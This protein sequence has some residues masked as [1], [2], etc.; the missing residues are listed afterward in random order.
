MTQ[1][2]NVFLHVTET[3]NL[4]YISYWAKRW[5]ISKGRELEIRLEF[6]QNGFAELYI[7]IE[8]F[9]EPKVYVQVFRVPG[10][11]SATPLLSLLSNFTLRATIN[12]ADTNNKIDRSR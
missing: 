2:H 8:G 4:Y 10:K 5:P 11:A 7:S 6:K 1:C 12:S 3:V 9:Y